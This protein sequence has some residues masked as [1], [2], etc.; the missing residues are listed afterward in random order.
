MNYKTLTLLF[1]L[2]THTGLQAEEM[3]NHAGHDMGQMSQMEG[4][5]EMAMTQG[6]ISRIDAA[7]GKVGIKHEAIDNLKM[8]AMTMVFRVADPALIQDLKV[9]DAVRFH[10]EN[11]A[12][13][14][15]VT[16]IQKQ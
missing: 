1:G 5:N 4:M 7:N 9:G 14:L 13:K 6:V 2:A 16:A 3:M 10:A 15:T 8:P 11:P 12:G